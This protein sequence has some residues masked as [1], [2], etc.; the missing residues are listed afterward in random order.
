MASLVLSAQSFFLLH[1]QACRIH[2]LREFG[3]SA[4][5][6]RRVDGQEIVAPNALLAST[7]TVHD[8]RWSYSMWETTT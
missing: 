1:I 2:I 6:F 4:T 5:A 3:L 8:L 7:K